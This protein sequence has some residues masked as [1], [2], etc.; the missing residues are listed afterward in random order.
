MLDAALEIVAERGLQALTHRGIEARADVSHGVTTYYFK[1]REALIEALYEHMCEAQTEWITGLYAAMAL[2]ARADPDGFRP[3]AYTRKAVNILLSQRSVLLARYEMYL[4]AARNPHLRDA[5]RRSRDRY[6]DIQ[7]EMFRSMGA[8]DPEL[9][10]RRIL[11]ATEGLLLYQVAMPE[12]DFE[13]WAAP[14]LQM[15]SDGLVE[16]DAA[17]RGRH[18]AWTGDHIS[19]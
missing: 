6:A 13:T 12:A 17:A 4:H 8:R 11:S 2:E 10:A 18:I 14:Y 16:F 3:D 15:I 9:A 1:N 19:F 5:A 7:I